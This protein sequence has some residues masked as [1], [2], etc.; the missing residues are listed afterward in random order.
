MTMMM[1]SVHYR[2]RSSKH[3]LPI[4]VTNVLFGAHVVVHLNSLNQ[5]YVRTII[6]HIR[7]IQREAI[8]VYLIRCWVLCAINV[9]KSI[10]DVKATVQYVVAILLHNT[11][12]VQHMQIFQITELN[13]LVATVN[14][15][16][17][18]S[19][20]TYRTNQQC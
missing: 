3:V 19:Q 2:I 7:L 18:V 8:S 17:V 13:L 5:I 20:E 16:R 15:N 10:E 6:L 11:I 12:I 4:L 14:V 9:E 1:M